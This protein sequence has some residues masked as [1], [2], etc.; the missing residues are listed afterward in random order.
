MVANFSVNALVQAVFSEY[1]IKETS[2]GEIGN[3]VFEFSI[4]ILCGVTD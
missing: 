2:G 1:A 3:I 4:A